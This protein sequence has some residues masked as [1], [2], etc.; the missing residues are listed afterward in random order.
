MASHRHTRYNLFLSVTALLAL[1]LPARASLKVEPAQVFPQAR[2]EVAPGVDTK[3]PVLLEAS[4]LYYD[5]ATGVVIATGEVHIT[6]NDT[7]VIADQL[8]YDQKQD[9]L[10]A[11]GNVSMLEPTGNVY[12]ADAVE[13]ENQMKA[14]VINEFK[15]RFSDDSLFAAAEARRIDEN[16]IELKKAVYSPC[17][18]CNDEGESV[19]P[20][21]QIKAKEV[22][23]NNAEQEVV[24]HDAYFEAYGLP[25]IYTPYLSHPTPNA[26]NQS[27]FLVPQYEHTNNLGSIVKVP[28]YYAIAPDKDATII[29]IYTSLEGLVMAG[30]YRQ[31]FDDGLLLTDGSITYPS[32]RDALG[33][34]STGRSI[35]GNINALGRFDV[36][37]RSQ[38]G[39]DIHRV[40][41]DTYLRRYNFSTEPL[42]TSTAYIEGFNFLGGGERSY[43]VARGL[44]FQGLTAEDDSGQI[45]T[46]FPLAD[47]SYQS[48]PGIYNSRILFDGNT[49]ALYRDDGARSRRASARVGW[50]LPYISDSGQVIEFTTSLRSDVYSVEDVSLTNGTQFDGVTGRVVPEADISWRYPFIN[51]WED[52]SVLI[53]PVIAA[54]ISPAGGNPETI[55]NEDSLVP[56]FTD[57]NLF[58]YNRYAGY[59]RIE[60]GPRISYGLR[61]QAQFWGDRYLSWLFGQHYRLVEDRNFPFSNEI[62]SN[63]SDYVGSLGI[64][65]MPV[66]LA[67]RFRMDKDD[68]SPKRSEIDAAFDY[69]PIG[70]TAAYVLLSDDPI[71]ANQE[72]VV[73]SSNVRLSKYWSWQSAANRNLLT[74]E[75]VSTSTGLTYGDECTNVSGIMGREFTRDRDIEP[76]TTFLLRIAFK[77]LN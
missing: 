10:F 67:Y 43:G 20:L 36:S 9:R 49:M 4:E 76:T 68:F 40:T 26:D 56:E 32:D 47:I 14:G 69:D 8:I 3:S 5:H 61:G 24:Y 71:L 6:Q 12:F 77:N 29:P 39:F 1:P 18:V 30:E 60:S 66:H 73:G 15:A 27:G 28:Y 38:W 75:W 7:V 45:P 23:I 21:W 70:L 51:Q 42:L 16:T 13:L 41:D 11:Q 44:A 48:P 19:L 59:D 63:F 37:E 33:N 65:V 34:K 74:D 22:T 54:A 58:A 72:Q 53:E 57:S 52:G 35:R 50:K 17:K 55:P 62:D 31:K 25:V 46:I 64:D 2:V